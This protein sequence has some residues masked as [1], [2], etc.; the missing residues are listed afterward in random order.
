MRPKEGT[1]R[2]GKNEREGRQEGWN[3]KRVNKSE[4]GSWFEGSEKGRKMC[5]EPKRKRE[6]KRR[7]ASQHGF[8]EK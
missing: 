1:K 5:T 6:I 7:H 2:E 3:E 8:R 4:R